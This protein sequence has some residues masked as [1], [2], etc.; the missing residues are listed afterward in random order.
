MRRTWVGGV[1]LLGLAGLFAVGC[2]GGAPAKGDTKAP[3][4]EPKAAA[5]GT[6]ID[7]GLKEFAIEPSA[8]TAK[9]GAVTFKATNKGTTPHELIVLKSDAAPNALPIKE[10]K[11]DLTGLTASLTTAE[12]ASGKAESKTADLTPGKYLLICNIP[13]HY[14]A[15][16][17]LA[18]TVQ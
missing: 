12:L 2:G 13:A 3:A 1:V 8:K 5:G 16:M 14:Q 10:A 9:P 6:T 4:G 17:T 11:A 15:G 7:V 18:F